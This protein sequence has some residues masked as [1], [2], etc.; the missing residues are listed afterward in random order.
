MVILQTEFNQAHGM[1]IEEY[2][3]NI[4]KRYQTGISRE[5]AYRGDLQQLLETLLPDTIVTNEPARISCG[6]PDYVITRKDIP[7]GY[8]EAKDI[9]VDLDKTLKSEQIKRYTA[10]L[11][12][13][14]L[15]DYVT[16]IFLKDGEEYET[17]ELF[18][19]YTDR[20]IVNGVDKTEQK[21]KRFEL[22]IRDFSTHITQTIKSPTKLASMMANKAKLLA[23]VINNALTSDVES[24]ANSSLKEQMEAFKQILIHDI[25]PAE[26]ADIYA[27]T[28]AYGMFAARLHDPTPDTFSRQ[29]AASLIPKSNPFLRKLFQYISGYDIDT[30][31][32]WIVSAL[33]D[34]FRA[35]DVAEI[36]KDFGKA[37]QMNDPF[38]HFY[39]F[40]LAEYD[41]KLRKA[42]GVWYTPEPVVNFIVRAVD[43]ILK[44]EFGLPKGLAD[45]SKTEIEVD[46]DIF[47]KKKQKYKKAK[48]QVHKVQI[49]DPATGTGTFLAEVVK[50]I[51]GTRF[52]NMQGAWPQ[53]V[54]NDLIPRL[55]GFEILMASYAMAHLKLDLLLGE[56]GYKATKD[57]RF[58]IYLTNSLEEAN[59]DTGTLFA[60]WLSTEASEANAVK[61]D[62]PVMC[63]IGNPPYSISSSNKGNW[64][65]NL[66]ID[67]KKGLTEKSYNSLSDDYVKFIRYGQ[68]YI[69]KNSSGILVFI[70]N[71]S[72]I[73]GLVHRNM[74]KNLLKTFDNIYIL[75]LHG[76]SKKKEKSPDGSIDQNVF[77]IMQGVCI[78]VFVK[79]SKNTLSEYASLYHAD[80]FG[81]RNTKYKYL[82]ENSLFSINWS[83][84]DVLEPN[85]FFT[86]K[87]FSGKA[88]YDKYVSIDD[89]FVKYN[90][91][92]ET[93]KDAFFYDQSETDFLNR[94]KVEFEN[95]VATINNYNIKDS[96]SF[97]FLRKF[98]AS[99]FDSSKIIEVNYRPFDVRKLYY[100]ENLQRRPAYSTMKH[101][102]KENLGLLV[103]RQFSSS[104]THVFISEN[105][106]DCNL[107]GTAKKFGSAPIFPIYLYL[108]NEN[109]IVQNEEKY[110]RT[111][112]LNVDIINRIQSLTSLEFLTEKD[113][114][115]KNSFSPIDVLDYIYGVLHSVKY[116]NKYNEFLRIAFPRIPLPTDRNQFLEILN[117]GRKIRKLHLMKT[118]DFDISVYYPKQGNN[119]VTR[120]ITKTSPGFELTNED[121]KTGKVWINDEQYFDNV[122][123]LAWNFY[124][125]GYQPAQKWLKDRQGRTLTYDDIE[126]YQKIIAV[127]VETDKIMKEID[128]VGVV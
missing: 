76:D 22:L 100:D 78:S 64:I 60:N 124:I 84:L 11:D 97:P 57:Q 17:L 99:H 86:K 45:N 90:N 41:P 107:T 67:Y 126:H 88:T 105:P 8:I 122:P 20:Q 59:P 71:N 2:T 65:E 35:T 21:H 16:F 32:E 114:A 85:Y 42:R 61:R 72:F 7:I 38:I 73:D 12:N 15:T 74:R 70:S 77:D 3:S 94:I 5:H 55:N 81:R 125:G 50:H 1:T 63:V 43:D 91:G 19:L 13:L 93:G 102:L 119:L 128:E 47:D 9:G 66:L 127:L 46:T 87:D 44:S 28:I 53:Y 101:M 80:L 23:Q 96:G 109:R 79:N 49:L 117:L 115:S 54:E 110:Q 25:K 118:S 75:D 40:F 103:P 123:E 37:T 31:I 33:A 10:S 62:T 18:D 106:T 58:K 68:H 89:I 29:E 116:R 92:I 26:F 6:S 56:T 112:N 113:K 51:Y 111:H 30:R 108:D 120:K 82:R 39:E 34:I 121:T 104:F 69:E 27:Q 24:N 14:I 48:K 52:K 4:K 36:L 83:E 95:R 98:N